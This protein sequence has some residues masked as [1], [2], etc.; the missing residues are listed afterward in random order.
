M[1]PLSPLPQHLLDVIERCNRAAEKIAR[2]RLRSPSATLRHA[3]ERK[4]RG[5]SASSSSDAIAALRRVRAKP[6]GN[7]AAVTALKRTARKKL[8]A[9]GS[10]S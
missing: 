6:G 9:Y 10:R 3:A 5:H 4:K 7:N 8:S 2:E 1:K